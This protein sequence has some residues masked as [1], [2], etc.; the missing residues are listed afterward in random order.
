M[1]V[2]A[3]EEHFATHDTV[4]AWQEVP[5]E[6]RDYAVEKSTGNDK[7]RLLVDLADERLARMDAAGVDVQV[8]SVT[9]PGVRSIA[10]ARTANDAMAHI[11]QRQP[12][13]FQGLATLPSSDPVRAAA[14]L[15]RAVV[16]LGLN[17]A[18][19]FGRDGHRNLDHADFLPILQTANDLRAPLYLH[20]QSPPPS[21]R[22]AYYEGFQH[23]LVAAFAT[24]G[25]GWHYET[26][27]QALRL[28]LSGVF[29]RLPDLQLILGHWGEVILFYL[30]RIDMLSQ[31][32]GLHRTVSDYVAAHFS[33]T[34]SGMFSDRYLRWA[35]ETLGAE[36][37]MFAT[38]YPFQIAPGDAARRFLADADL[39]QADRHAIASGNWERMC[40]GIRRLPT[41]D[42]R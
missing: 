38:D 37:I 5:A 6:V 15:E 2:V 23:D 27:V 34:P 17:G 8:L 39:S 11:I 21:V 20:P 26:G 29:D 32:A 18:M 10:L 35:M 19:I 24:A 12:D 30:D 3:L 22:A 31:P 36:R 7:E 4:E 14:E 28:I 1:K 25:I 9:T 41:R 40:A 16:D 33:V 42:C 13:R